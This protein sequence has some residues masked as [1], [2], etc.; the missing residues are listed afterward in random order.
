MGGEYNV[1]QVTYRH[2]DAIKGQSDD[3]LMKNLADDEHAP[4]N[5]ADIKRRFEG[6]EPLP[7]GNWPRANKI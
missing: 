2:P 5:L 7:F 4:V 1:T 3:R 6:L